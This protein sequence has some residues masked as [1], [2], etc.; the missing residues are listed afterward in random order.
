MRWFTR[1]TVVVAPMTL[2]AIG[3]SCGERREATTDAPQPVPATTRPSAREGPLF[4]F[5]ERDVDQ[6]LR[7]LHGTEP[8]LRRRVVTI[9]RRNIDQPYELYL[10]GESPFETIDAQPVYCLTKSDCVV[11]AEHTLAMALS[12]D[13]PSFLATLQRI[14]YRDGAIGV[15]TRNHYTEA[16]WNRSNAWLVRDVTDEIG[17]SGVV[18]FKQTVNRAKFFKDRYKLDTS[19]PNET[20]DESFIPYEH[21]GSVKHLLRDGDV[22]NFVSGVGSNYWVG[23]VGLAALGPN[24]EVHLVHSA[25]PRVREEPIE[26]YVRRTTADAAQKD[27]AGK[28]RFRGFKFLRLNEDALVRLRAIDGPAAPRVSVPPG[29]PMTWEQYLTSFKLD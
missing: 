23:H 16:D 25:A 15:L 17:G 26:E 8:D 21:V 1:W 14:R 6:Y 4:Q 9:A 20:I 11:F 19:L 3:I 10:L 13:W 2:S 18:R 27:A 28:A 29:S 24:G 12:S 7:S 22:V 5:S